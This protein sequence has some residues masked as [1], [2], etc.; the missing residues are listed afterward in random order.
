MRAS[1]RI[2]GRDHD[3]GRLRTR[4]VSVE[5]NDGMWFMPEI[6]SVAGNGAFR[7]RR[8]GAG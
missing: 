4:R 2:F 1:H 7:V 6:D 8:G 5:S 3:D